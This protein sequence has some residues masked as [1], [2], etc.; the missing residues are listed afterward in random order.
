MGKLFE[1]LKRR[2]VIRVAAIYAVVAWLLI[3]VADTIAP[4]MNLPESAPSLVLFLLI[5]LFPIAVFLAWAY[6]VT[7]EGIKAETGNQPQQ[8]ISPGIDRKLIYATFALVLFA[9][10]FQ[11]ADRFLFNDQQA[12]TQPP[13]TAALS[14]N[15]PVIRFDV[16]LSENDELYL[17]G[18]SSTNIGRP[19]QTSLAL[20]NDGN[21]LVYSGWEEGPDGRSSRLYRRRLDQERAEPIPGTEGGSGPFFSPDD[22][23]IGF[24]SR[25]GGQ[26]ALK[27]V[28]MRDGNIET[29]VADTF[30]MWSATWGDDGNI[31]FSGDI[32]L[33]RVAASGGEPEAIADPR[34]PNSVFT[35]YVKPH[36][37]P[38]AVKCCCFMDS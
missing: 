23:W 18:V 10:G 33:F 11:V 20:S 25:G 6:E 28:S 19:S 31:V 34:T 13:A 35:R 21:M 38:G 30:R 37:L 29:I 27:R 8:S 22:E 7:P 24:N 5:I 1:E 2:K 14:Q 9:V 4:M 15:S 26:R 3:Q 16:S 17:G 32:R 12:A 36:L